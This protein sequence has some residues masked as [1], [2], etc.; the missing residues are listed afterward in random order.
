MAGDLKD[1]HEPGTTRP[2]RFKWFYAVP[3]GRAYFV[4][5]LL[6][7]AI[8]LLALALGAHEPLVSDSTDYREMAALLAGGSHF[9]PY[10]PPG[11]PLY[12]AIFLSAGWGDAVLR[13]STLLWWVL[14]CWSLYRLAWDLQVKRIAWVV[15]L[16]FAIAP[17]EVHFSIEPMTQMPGAA[18]LL[19]ALS[20]AVRCAQGAGWAEY[21]LLGGSL[22][23]LSLVRPSVLPLLI[24][25]P[26]MVF[27]R[28][29][30]LVK[31]LIA[32]VIGGTMI[33]GW[34]LKV[35]QVGGIWA[36]NTANT[37]NLYYGNNP[38]TPM[39]RTWFF[40]SHAK[41]GSDEIL[42]F[43]EYA[44]TMDR[45]LALPMSERSDAYKKLA[46]DYV[47]HHPVI[48]FA[49]TLNRIRCFWGFD[50]FTAVNLRGVPDWKHS[51]F[52][53]VLAM[54]AIC[55]LFVTGF[56][57]FWIACA[58]AAFWR[59]W[60]VWL[61]AGTVVLY[62]LP[63]WISMSHPTYHFPV[64]APLALLGAIAYGTVGSRK[65]HWRGWVGVVALGLIQVEWIYYLTQG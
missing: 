25:L 39:Y 24:V 49:R 63:Y 5:F 26:A 16:V 12:L 27:L 18:L 56:A 22:G 17:A 3:P 33:F 19:L 41:F 35:H 57:V 38:W 23:Y 54:D 40:G 7:V 50:T 60:D 45:A 65:A 52:P 9:L 58:P 29:K 42:N 10:W 64:V 55:Y 6:S 47:V 36:I 4:V 43:P 31:P 21:L 20:A 48:F 32:V 53:V 34:M 11:L 61:L 1:L 37:I 46:V 14:F 44:E 28:R 59:R 30:D 13:A 8:R 62:G 15:L 2:E 51:L